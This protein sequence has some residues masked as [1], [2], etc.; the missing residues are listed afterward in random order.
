MTK[1]ISQLERE[2]K[3]ARRQNESLM[4]QL[5]VQHGG[6]RST[7]SDLSKDL[8]LLQ[9]EQQVSEKLVPEEEEGTKDLREKCEARAQ[10]IKSLEKQNTDLAEQVKNFEIDC[11][12]EVEENEVLKSEIESLKHKLETLSSEECIEGTN[13]D[14]ETIASYRKVLTCLKKQVDDLND[15]MVKLRDHSKKQS[16][17]IL[18]LKQQ[19]EMTEVLL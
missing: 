15:D 6:V 3:R 16:R 17:Q 2:L 4:E 5:Q 18:K 12:V 10:R 14:E 7:H 13:S 19:S 1:K 11:H 8:H 9:G